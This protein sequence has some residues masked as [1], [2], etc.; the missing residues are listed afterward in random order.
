M[1]GKQLKTMNTN[2]SSSRNFCWSVLWWGK[3]DSRQSFKMGEIMFVHWWERSSREGTFDIQEERVTGVKTWCGW[4]RMG[5]GVR[6]QAL[7]SEKSAHSSSIVTG[8]EAKN[9]TKVG[10]W[11]DGWGV[12]TF[13]SSLDWFCFPQLKVRIRKKC[14]RFREEMRRFLGLR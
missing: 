12:G 8:G 13:G 2:N 6:V 1:E 11:V 9:G 5:S 3:L 4:E 10:R 7:V 14:W